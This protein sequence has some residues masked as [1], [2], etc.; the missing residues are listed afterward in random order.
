M[1]CKHQ[2][3]IGECCWDCADEA[4]EENERSQLPVHSHLH[5]QCSPCPTSEDRVSPQ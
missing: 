1:L 5:R 4:T 3:V 2:V